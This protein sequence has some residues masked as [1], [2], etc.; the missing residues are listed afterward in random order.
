M[1]GRRYACGTV[2]V[3]D[4]DE[5]LRTLVAEVLAGGGFESVQAGTGEEALRLAFDRQPDVV[6][7]DVNL[8]DT[9]GYE[10]C[11]RLKESDPSL[12][13][14]FLSGERTESF[15]RVA[16]LLIGGDD[17]MIKPFAPDE[18]LARI[19]CVLKRGGPVPSSR[20][21]SLTHRE[22]Q[23]LRLLAAGRSQAEIADELVI[24]AKTVGTHIEHILG[25]LGVHSRSQ[26]IALAYRDELVSPSP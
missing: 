18:L 16:G 2:L 14:I 23:V 10:V 12:P 13:V 26:A 11:R 8:P 15:D 24:S 4:D 22:R 21:A 3:V 25:K 1:A 9:S 17:Y 5:C 7:L 19:N 20:M 6:L